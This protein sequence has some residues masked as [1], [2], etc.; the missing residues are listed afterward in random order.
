MNQILIKILKQKPKIEVQFFLLSLIYFIKSCIK[1]ER[2]LKKALLV[3]M[4]NLPLSQLLDFSRKKEIPEEQKNPRGGRK[5][6]L[7]FWWRVKLII[8]KHRVAQ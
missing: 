7:M 4:Q 2:D 1:S 3:N 6:A 5:D 8:D